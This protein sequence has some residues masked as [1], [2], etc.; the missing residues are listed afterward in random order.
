MQIK[1]FE[2][3]TKEDLEKMLSE[4]RAKLRDLRY[5]IASHQLKQVHLVD[6]TKKQIARIRTA[7]NQK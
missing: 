7:M 2:G 1:E 4:A 3:K 5:K 6:Q